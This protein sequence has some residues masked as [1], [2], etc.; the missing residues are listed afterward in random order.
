MTMHGVLHSKSHVDRVYHCR[1]MRGR[2][3]ISF[4][5]CI[6]VRE[7]TWGVNTMNNYGNY[8]RNYVK[9]KTMYGQFVR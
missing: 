7:T 3:L 6:T 2:G 8:V 9:N 1:K 4:E 5:G